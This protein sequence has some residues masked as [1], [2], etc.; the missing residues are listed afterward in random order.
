M[1]LIYFCLIISLTINASFS[2]SLSNIN[3]QPHREYTEQSIFDLENIPEENIDIGLWSLVIAKEYDSTVDINYYLTQLDEMVVE[4]NRMIAGRDGDMLKFSMTKMFIYD[5]GQWNNKDPFSYDLNDPFGKDIRKKLLSYYIDNKK[6]NCISMP[7][8]FLS[9]MERVDP[10][11]QFS[12]V[13]VPR[14][15]F[16]RLYDSQSGEIWNVETTNGGTPARDEWYIEQY[17]ITQTGIDSGL[18]LR[19]LT[20]KEYVGELCQILSFK[21]RNEEDFDK[22]LEYNRLFLRL[23]NNSATA[24]VQEGALI[25]W[26]GISLQD[27]IKSQKRRPT[28]VEYER[29]KFYFVESDKYINLAKSKGWKPETQEDREDYLKTIL[30][31]KDK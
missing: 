18:F 28:K 2:Q 16:C 17:N 4:I 27:S 8:L 21:Y 14:H 19:T 6:G 20:K 24:L 29:L 15:L 10:N 11:I 12:G 7:T 22:A 13:T 1:G 25:A 31:E 26:K 3:Y 9:L 23:N 30:Q 5:T